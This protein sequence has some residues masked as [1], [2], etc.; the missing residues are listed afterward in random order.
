MSDASSMQ[1]IELRAPW[2]RLAYF[3]RSERISI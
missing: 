3:G 2:M 1:A